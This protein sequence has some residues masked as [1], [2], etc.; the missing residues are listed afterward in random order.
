MK[1]G[2]TD[3]RLNGHKR[4]FHSQGLKQP[5]ILEGENAAQ[6]YDWLEQCQATLKH[7]DTFHSPFTGETKY[8]QYYL[9]NAKGLMKYVQ[10]I[11]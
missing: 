2:I 11:Q 6:F 10:D 7:G 3:P 5:V 8:E 9:K 4:Y 1:K